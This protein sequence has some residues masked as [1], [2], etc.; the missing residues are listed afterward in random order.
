M[1]NVYH[2]YWLENHV[3]CFSISNI[4]NFL[5]KRQILNNGPM[6]SFAHFFLNENYWSYQNKK[7]ADELIPKFSDLIAAK[8]FKLFCFQNH[9]VRLLPLVLPQPKITDFD[10]NSS[11]DSFFSWLK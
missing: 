1:T 7:I 10:F 3:N 4:K 11:T 2:A 9:R 8:V 6:G 5:Q